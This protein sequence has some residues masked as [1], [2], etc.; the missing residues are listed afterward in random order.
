VC[1][2]SFDGLLLA[3]A[4][5][6]LPERCLELL[7]QAAATRIIAATTP[8]HYRFIHDLIR[9]VLYEEL[10]A[11]ERPLV[12]LAVARALQTRQSYQ[13]A[14]HAAVLAHH[15][16]V[17][18]HCGGASSA[19]D[20]SI[21]AGAYALRNFAYEE[22]IEHF[23]EASRLL[24]LSPEADQATECAV[25]LDLGLAQISAGRREAGQ[26]T[27]QLAAQKARVLGSAPELASVALNL[28]PGLFAIETGVY[29][30]TLVGLLREALDLAG[31]A[32]PKLRALLL[33][34]L[35]LAMY[36]SD[37]FAERVAICDEARTLG[38]QV[39]SDDVKARVATARLFALL[40]P[41]N[42]EERRMLS[43][44][45]VE[46]CQ[47]T[48]DRDGLLVT[49]LQRAAIALE[50]G[51]LAGQ[52][53][54]ADAFRTLAE[55]TKQPQALWIVSA[56]SAC[57]LLMQG[58]LELVEQL[59][60]ACLIAGQRVQDHNALLTFG[61]LL[62]FVR[63]EQGRGEEVLDVVRDFAARYPRIVG[64]RAVYTFVLCRTGRKAECAVEYASLKAADF[65]VPDDLTWL[66]SMA[67]FAEVSHAQADA[68]GARIVYDRLLPFASRLVVVGYA[69]I[70][71]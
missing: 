9:E 7:R 8:N 15:F 30:P 25:L 3:L 54:E 5:G 18:A 43:D 62:T 13:D 26:S 28:A 31:N 44:Q 39:G 69:G 33:A 22:A 23:A 19:V 70:R 32:D 6:L 66:L 10:D 2:Q 27:L 14:R 47:R 55:E 67:I 41:S 65:A 17:A 42:L 34:R 36:W 56:Q 40:R 48:G 51:D 57:R 71:A 49:R 61:L 59:A 60:G 1:G 16:R 46:L 12:H 64:W 24:P 45:A 20:L 63:V 35:A 29:D 68:E 37:T 50:L 4:A 21:R 53:F 11:T 52:A 38:E 58:Q